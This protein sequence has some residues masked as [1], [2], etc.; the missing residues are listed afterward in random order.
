MSA[1]PPKERRA[2]E[3]MQRIISRGVLPHATVDY[4][5]HDDAGLPVAK[6]YLRPLTQFELDV[7]RANARAY[8]ARLVNEQK[9]ASVSWKP[10]ELEDNATAAEILAVACRHPDDPSKPFF[11]YGAMETRECTTEELAILFNHYNVIR[12]RSYPTFREMSEADFAAWLKALE[13]DAEAFPFS[14]ISRSRLE[15]FCVWAARY[16]GSTTRQLLG[17]ISNTSPASPSST[18]DSDG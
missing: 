8:V 6:V 10:E 7:A 5:R 4:P 13:E 12:E 1:A 15:A 14:L 17:M 9:G 11:P 2:G 18:S 16:L 3:L